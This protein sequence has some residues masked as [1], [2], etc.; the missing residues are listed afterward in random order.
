MIFLRPIKPTRNYSNSTWPTVMRSAVVWLIFYRV[1]VL[2]WRLLKDLTVKQCVMLLK[3]FAECRCHLY[4]VFTDK[5]VFRLSTLYETIITDCTR[6]RQLCQQRRQTS[7]R[8]AFFLQEWHSVGRC[9]CP[10][11]IGLHRFDVSWLGVKSIKSVTVACFCHKS[12]SSSSV[13]RSSIRSFCCTL[14]RK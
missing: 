8:N 9:R 11:K 14:N 3:T 1:L 6:W 7:R 2:Q 10:V 4:V 12:C 5:N 13:S